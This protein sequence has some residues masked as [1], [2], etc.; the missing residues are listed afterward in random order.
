MSPPCIERRTIKDRREARRA[1]F[2]SQTRLALTDEKMLENQRSA[3]LF[4]QVNAA[5]HKKYFALHHSSDTVD[6][7]E[8]AI[9]F[10]RCLLHPP[11]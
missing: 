6:F 2:F 11:P 8:A 9:G 3:L 10:R 4:R 5:S 7:M 1:A